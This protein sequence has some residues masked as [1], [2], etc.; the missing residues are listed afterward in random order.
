MKRN[1][2][3]VKEV[4]LKISQKSQENNCVGVSFLIKLQASVSC[5]PQVAASERNGLISELTIWHFLKSRKILTYNLCVQEETV[6][7]NLTRYRSLF[8][9][10]TKI[11]FTHK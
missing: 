4:S 6:V 3:F 8:L 7:I 10:F 1:N 2:R 9:T 11:H 5:T